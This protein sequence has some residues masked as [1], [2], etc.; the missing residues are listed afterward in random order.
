LLR[1]WEQQVRFAVRLAVTGGGNRRGDHREGDRPPARPVHRDP[2]GLRVR[3]HGAG[4]AEPYPAGLLTVD[5]DA[6]V[7]AE[8]T[9]GLR[10]HGGVGPLS[11]SVSESAG[12]ACPVHSHLATA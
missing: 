11:P 10:H 5:G 6:W 1:R 2:V 12:L 3:R 7:S 9:R 8:M 4:L